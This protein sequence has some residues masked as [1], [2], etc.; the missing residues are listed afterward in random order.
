MTQEVIDALAD[1][2]IEARGPE[3][4][5]WHPQGRNRHG[6]GLTEVASDSAEKALERLPA[7]RE[8]WPDLTWSVVRVETWEH[9]HVEPEATHG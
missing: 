7:P 5:R 1:L 3:H 6:G 9:R 4:V 2:D 8:R